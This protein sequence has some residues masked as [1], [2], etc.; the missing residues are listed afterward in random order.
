MMWLI[1]VHSDI[2]WHNA[3]VKKDGDLGDDAFWILA[4]GGFGIVTGLVIYGYKIMHTLGTKV[5]SPSS[6]FYTTIT[7]PIIISS[8][9]A[10]CGYRGWSSRLPLS[11]DTG[12]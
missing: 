12:F 8:C 3:K 6:P 5:S 7:F 10:G 9:T 1:G 2:T 4:L 11:V